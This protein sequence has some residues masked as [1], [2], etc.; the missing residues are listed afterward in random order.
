MLYLYRTTCTRARAPSQVSSYLKLLIFP[1]LL[2]LLTTIGENCC[3][4]SNRCSLT[5]LTEFAGC[6]VDG[7]ISPDTTG[8]NDGLKSTF[9]Q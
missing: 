2:H 1:E 9:S 5:S 3:R 6:L 4:F 7:I 8:T